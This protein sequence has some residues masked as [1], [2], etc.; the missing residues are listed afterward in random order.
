MQTE[1]QTFDREVFNRSMLLGSIQE[2]L[3][4]ATSLITEQSHYQVPNLNIARELTSLHSKINSALDQG[5]PALN[6][7][8]DEVV[9]KFLGEFY[10]FLPN[11][12]MSY[13]ASTETNPFGVKLVKTRTKT[14]KRL[15]EKL[16]MG[17]EV[18]DTYGLAIVANSWH[19][20]ETNVRPYLMDKFVV[21]ADQTN[22]YRDD[23]E[24]LKGFTSAQ[25]KGKMSSGYESEHHY[26]LFGD[27]MINVHLHSLEGFMEAEWGRAALDRHLVQD[28]H[29]VFELARMIGLG[30]ED[31]MRLLNQETDVKTIMAPSGKVLYV[32]NGYESK[33]D[34]YKERVMGKLAVFYKGM[35]RFLDE[36]MRLPFPELSSPDV[37]RVVSD[38]V[39]K[40]ADLA[41]VYRN[42][43]STDE[44]LH[45]TIRKVVGIAERNEKP[46]VLH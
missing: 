9:A 23:V 35:E 27:T 33:A 13:F 29:V 30:D 14:T 36:E 43:T 31:L 25:V 32:G 24:K 19:D 46:L 10:G 28:S 44:L 42:P 15:I 7:F 17:E 2:L 18:R 8:R 21:L 16:M 40:H 5:N 22:F 12:N 26:V 38:V 1:K 45:P 20:I 11:Q 39:N 41:S 6:H 34:I 37:D 3:E 4:N